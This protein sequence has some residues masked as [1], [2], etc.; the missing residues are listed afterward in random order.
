MHV[1]RHPLTLLAS[2]IDFGQCVECWELIE[3]NSVPGLPGPLSERMRSA[4]L[5]NRLASVQ[6]KLQQG[7]HTAAGGNQ[8]GRA[9]IDELLRGFMLY[10]VTWN[11]VVEAAAGHRFQVETAN[12]TK[13]CDL[14]WVDDPAALHNGVRHQPHA[15]APAVVVPR[16][17]H[18]SQNVPPKRGQGAA[19]PRGKPKPAVPRTYGG[20]HRRATTLGARRETCA[21]ANAR[22]SGAPPASISHGGSK[23]NVT[24]ARLE[25]IDPALAEATW[26][27]AQR[28]GYERDPPNHGERPE[29][30]ASRA[31]VVRPPVKAP[32]PK[33]A[34]AAASGDRRCRTG[35]DGV[36][37]CPPPGARAGGPAGRR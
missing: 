19:G 7:S 32:G 11:P 36:F 5:A 12:Y 33:T 29:A 4:L 27:L 22:V 25:H 35:N 6:A 28:Y 14:A 17:P 13:V 23:H 10:Y 2:S 9:V 18:R 26:A 1:V 20:G 16:L 34:K 3:S 30:E 31:V 8:W 15:P 24:W 21:E 37:R